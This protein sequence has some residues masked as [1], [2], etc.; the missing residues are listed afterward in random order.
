M[1]LNDLE[2]LQKRIH[3]FQ[4]A[5]DYKKKSEI[6][7]QLKNLSNENNFWDNKSEA[8]KIL[9][10]ISEIKETLEDFELLQNKFDDLE[11]LFNFYDNQ[12]IEE[13][14]LE[15]EFKKFYKLLADFEIQKILNEE[16][17]KNPAIVEFTPGAGGTE[18]QDWGEMLMRMY[19]MWAQSNKYSVHQLDYQKG[20]T[21][22][23][24]S[25]T[26]E[27]SGKLAYGYLKG[28]T[29]IHRLVRISPFNAAG[30]RQTSFASVNVYPLV[31]NKIQIEI[32]PADI[33]WETY[34]SGGAGGQNV[35]KVETAVRIR[36]LPSGLIVECQQE[37]SQGQ[38]KEKALAILKSKLYQIELEKQNQKNKE[39]EN[40]KKQI[41][42]GSQIR[43]YVLHP[44]KLVKDLRTNVEK[45][46]VADVLNGD[47]NDFIQAEVLLF[48]NS[49]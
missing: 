45:T 7:K 46:N 38:N 10:Q 4:E 18:S 22:G 20:D 37:R 9:K 42:F 3:N 29:G 17:D 28:E 36:H 15:I 33:V 1:K 30:K 24:K 13:G 35:N 39:I 43:N 40:Q 31:D 25:A 32:N 26:L 48:G 34:R 41:D 5:L 27:I 23:L 12:E 6:Y 8:E 47:L 44:Y 49:K 16:T 2:S 11:V 21:A 14:E 19:I